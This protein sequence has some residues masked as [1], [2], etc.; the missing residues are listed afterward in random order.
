MFRRKI[1]SVINQYFVGNKEKI[2]VIDGARQVGKSYIVRE[3]GKAHFKNYVEINLKDDNEGNGNFS[4]EKTSTIE[5]F[6][7]HLSS[8]H[9]DRLGDKN[10]TLIFLDEIQVYPHLLT[11]LKALKKDDRFTYIVSGSLLGVTLKHAFI[12]MGSID[13]VRMYPLDFEEFCFASHVGKEVIDYLRGCYKE[14]RPVEEGVHETML[15]RFK[16]YLLCGGLPDAV[17]EFVINKN[18]MAM[19]KVH[20]LTQSYY[21]DDCVQYDNEHALKIARIYSMLPSYMENKVKRIVANKIAHREKDTFV[22][23]QDEFD[24][25]ISSGLVLPTKAVSDPRFPL[26][27]SSSKNLM[28]LYYNDVGLLTNILYK[29]NI[30]AVLS[31][32]KGV[33]LGSVYETAAAMELAAHSH[34]FFYFDSKK[35]GEVDFLIN[36]Y[37]A[38][39]V[40]P[41]EIKSGDD[42]Y[43]FRALPKLVDPVGRYCLKKGYVLGNKNIVRK[44]GNIVTLPIYMIM[45]I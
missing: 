14:L 26:L 42:Q 38:S 12:P 16:E 2:L 25:L 37:D 22:T 23:Y 28:K 5:S 3:L 15:R 43:N 7:L 11:M 30:D 17:K 27:E 19:R 36:D 20:E 33:N 41:I 10:D 39:S 13:E 8:L 45:F 35:T 21:K 24:Y 1:E 44:E 32:D 34:D 4:K 31:V 6:Y 9:G 40:L 18:V 29:N